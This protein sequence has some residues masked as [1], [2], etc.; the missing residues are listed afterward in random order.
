[1]TIGEDRVRIKFNPSADGLVDKIKQKSAELIDLC[2]EGKRRDFDTTT[3]NPEVN[4]L[5]SLAQ[6]HYE[7]AA[8][9]GVK[10]ATYSK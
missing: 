9:W 1:M 6:T 2:E 7:D 8:M 10:A 4:R 3:T 5:W